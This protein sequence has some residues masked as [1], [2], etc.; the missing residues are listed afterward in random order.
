MENDIKDLGCANGWRIQPEEYVKC[1]GLGHKLEIK[2]IGRCYE[3]ITCPECK[4][5]WTV[6]SSD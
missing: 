1:Q 3:R 4:I 6:D 5:S 2:V